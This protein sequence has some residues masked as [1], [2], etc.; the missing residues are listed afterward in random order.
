MV[1]GTAYRVC[2]ERLE[3]LLSPRVASRT[4]RMGMQPE[5]LAPDTVT[6]DELEPVL[7]GPV[8]KQLQAAMP[9]DAA[10]DA[11]KEILAAMRAAERPP[12]E[13]D[14][15]G[16]EAEEAPPHASGSAPA[17]GPADTDVAAEAP[18][19]D[20]RAVERLEAL[21]QALRPY[22]LYFEWPEVRRLRAHLQR[23]E[24][25]VERGGDASDLA[26]EADAQLAVLGSKLEDMLVLQA[27]DLAELEEAVAEVQGLGG[28]KLRRLD[29]LVK[30]VREA[31]RNRQLVDAEIE[32]GR[33][34]AR[35]LRK[36]MASSVWA[37]REAEGTDD[38]EV[39]A[40]L[41]ALDLEGEGQDLAAILRQHAVLL[42]HREDL[43]AAARGHRER[44]AEGHALGAE[45]SSFR[46]TLGAAEAERRREVEAELDAAAASVARFEASVAHDLERELD[47]LRG[48]LEDGLPPMS[49]LVRFGDLLALARDRTERAGRDAEADAREAR[50]RLDAQGERLARARN[51][52]LR[53]QESDGGPALE[54]LREAVE[55]LR[56]AQAEERL[57]PEA[58]GEVRQATAELALARAA[59]DA[60]GAGTLEQVRALLA[61]LEGVPSHVDPEGSAEFRR[62]LEAWLERPPSETELAS[63]AATVA[64]FVDSVRAVA[65]A[66]LDSAGAEAAR[67][68][69]RE[70][71]GAVQSANERLEDGRDPELGTVERS[72]AEA[73]EEVQR[74]QLDRLHHVERE[75]E[76]L[77]GI[78]DGLE[79]DLQNAL[80]RGRAQIGDGEPATALQDAAVLVGRLEATLA[81]RIADVEPRIDTA[82]ASFRKVERLNSD[83]VATVRRIL[84]HL[85]AQRDAFG[86]ISPAMRARLERSLQ[87]AEDLLGTLEEEE[88]ATRAIAD[89][90]MAGNR[91]DDVLGLFGDGEDGAPSW[92]AGD[93]AP[94]GPS[95]PAEEEAADAENED[96]NRARGPS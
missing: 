65:R 12:E 56:Q 75:A 58:D 28:P 29:A 68:G 38:A 20:A 60:D 69:L 76:R 79:N 2:V 22:N 7:K 51:D 44:L 36:L 15:E 83:D 11:V 93:D 6:A 27:K 19:R 37:S 1:T 9:A 32:R 8:F 33:R 80:A 88:R 48:M 78:D 14:A 61:R 92:A 4:L 85:D 50:A 77:V 74:S 57:D 31:Q 40:R 42:E 35:D 17:Q 67:W 39:E 87:E 55:R 10:R 53:H 46:E 71:I 13:R 5:G 3:R 66:R 84:A 18:E 43:A 41:K 25:E 73:R 47:V 45:L 16:A 21:R 90:L 52:L 49:D 23:V 86:R 59:G 64:A 96:E 81:R 63:G 62:D 54:R 95:E 34:L 24:E 72:L 70:V 91:F 30:H 82:I 26:D 89:R 94:D